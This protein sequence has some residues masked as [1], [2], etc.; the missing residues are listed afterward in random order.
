VELSQPFGAGL[1]SVSVATFQAQFSL[2]DA[3]MA[4][5]VVV[6]RE[7][8]SVFYYQTTSGKTHQAH[9]DSSG[10]VWTVCGLGNNRKRNRPDRITGTCPAHAITCKRCRG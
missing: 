6:E 3:A 8:R 1:V 7:A 9:E 5:P 4:A 10:Q 2:V